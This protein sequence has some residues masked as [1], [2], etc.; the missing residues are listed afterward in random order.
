MQHVTALAMTNLADQVVLVPLAT[1]VAIGFGLAGWYRGA[2]IWAATFVATM[3]AMGLLKLFFMTCGMGE[4]MVPGLRSPSG[5]TAGAAVV[6]GGL[7][8]LVVRLLTGTVHWTTLCAGLVGAMFG[9]TRL[10][11]GVHTDVEV[12]V[13]ACVGVGGALAMVHLSGVP[14]HPLR[15]GRTFAVG[16]VALPLLYGIHLPAEAMVAALA[17]RLSLLMACS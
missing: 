11:L 7:F 4:M 12:L 9:T 13:G 17:S 10:V 5:H 6:Y 8:A 15:F 1:I 3:S 16:L 14:P 2:A